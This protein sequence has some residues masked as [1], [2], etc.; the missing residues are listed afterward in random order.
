MGVSINN[1]QLAIF[2]LKLEFKNISQIPAIF[3]II[4]NKIKKVNINGKYYTI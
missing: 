2:K 4:T 1:S 3:I